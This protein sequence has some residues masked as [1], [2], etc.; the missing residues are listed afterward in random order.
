MKSQSVVVQ[1]AQGRPQQLILLFHGYGANAEDLVPLGARLAAAF[2]NANVVSVGARQ[3]TGYPGGLQWFSLDGVTDDN[4][5]D[6][7]A[8]AMPG[9]LAQIRAWQQD[10]GVTE[11]VTALVGFSQGAIMALES[12]FGQNPPAAR[13]IAIAGRFARL[14]ERA[15]AQTTIHLLHGKEDEVIPYRHTIDAAQRLLGLGGDV[16]ADVFPFVGHGISDEL[17]ELAVQRLRSHVPKRLWDE[18][19]RAEQKI[20]MNE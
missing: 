1:K 3:P 11:S 5:A 10:A 16:T 15:P 19:M 6:R 18:A 7:V 14:P 13:V 20:G 8:G 17:A 2:P 12:S 9:F 4:R